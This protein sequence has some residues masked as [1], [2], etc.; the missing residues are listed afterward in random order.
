MDPR[1]VIPTRR[2]LT[3]II[4][5]KAAG[6]REKVKKTLSEV[7]WL[8]FTTDGWTSRRMVGFIA[9][10]GHYIDE[11]GHLQTLLMGCDSIAGS[12][13]GEAIAE[14]LHGT[15]ISNGVNRKI[16]C[17]VTDSASN[18]KAGLRVGGWVRISCFAHAINLIAKEAMN[19]HLAAIAVAL[20]QNRELTKEETG[21]KSFDDV[22]RKVRKF[23][24]RLHRSRNAKEEFNRCQKQARKDNATTAIEQEVDTRWNSAYVMLKTFFELKK[25]VCL[26]SGTP[27]GEDFTFPKAEWDI[28]EHALEVLEPLYLVTVE[29][30]G[31]KYVSGSK[32]IPLTK[33][34]LGGYVRMLAKY[35]SQLQE[36][37]YTFAQAVHR[38]LLHHLSPVEQVDQLGLATLCDPRFKKI[39]F[40]DPERASKAVLNLR[41]EMALNLAAAA[42]EPIPGPSVNQPIPAPSAS[43]PI[44]GPSA[45]KQRKPSKA[46]WDKKKE[47][48]LWD[49]LDT[50]IRQTQTTDTIEVSVGAEVA[51]YLKMPNQPRK[52]DPLKWWRV[53]GQ[54]LYPNI[55]TAAKKYLCI[56]GTSVPSERGMYISRVVQ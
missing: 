11:S 3:K 35:G 43:E 51:K 14:R 40:R 49:L 6:R 20:K 42:N 29:M 44:P 5:K 1:Y 10:T 24:E 33:I 30:S 15:F 48:P 22:R 50:E 34:L 16:I 12:E 9:I 13:T 38:G 25:A 45:P 32:V 39:A 17:G 52:S 27:E 37:R 31:E 47:N 53:T 41:S 26:F 19:V 2:S 21:M 55:W 8:S 28:I 4:K 7:K 23:V 46:L 36:F 18:V 56:P 54:Y